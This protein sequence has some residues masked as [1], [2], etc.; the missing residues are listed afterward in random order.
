[1][2][3]RGS[4]RVRAAPSVVRTG[5]V[6]PLAQVGEEHARFAP[7]AVAFQTLAAGTRV[8]ASIALARAA[9]RPSLDSSSK[10]TD[11]LDEE[12]PCCRRSTAGFGGNSRTN[13]RLA[14]LSTS[15]RLL[16]L[17][18]GIAQAPANDQANVPAN[19]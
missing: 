18:R 1:N 11:Q 2:R 19:T 4:L 5:C 9:T 6:A 15:H 7:A 3:G 13:Q 10:Q 14:S 16:L 12:S 17:P 8:G